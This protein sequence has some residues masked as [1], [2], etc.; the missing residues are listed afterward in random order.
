MK[1][2]FLI[3][4]KD[5][6]LAF[7]DRAALILM[8]AAPFALTL[9]MGFVT[10]RFSG[11]SNT[12]VG[13]IP[14]IVVNQDG[15]SLGNALVEAFQSPD[16]QT[17][18]AP[19]T[20]NDPAA[21]RQAVDD[22]QAAAAVI[23]PAGFTQSILPGGSAEPAAQVVQIELYTNPTRSTSAGVASTIVEE[24]LNRLEVGRVG[25]LVTATQLLRRGIA[26]PQQAAAIGQET[27]TRLAAGQNATAITLKSVTG[28]GETPKF[29]ILAYMA[30][31][32]ALMF[33]MYTASNGGRTLLTERYQGT[34]PRLLV[35][36]TSTAQ[37]FAGKVFGIFLTGAAQML[38][39][40]LASGLLFQLYWGDPLGVLALVLAA[41]V[42]A[43]GWGLLITA[44]ARTP[45]QVAG[46]GSAI[47]LTFGI[48]GGSFFN[49][50]QMPGWFQ[51]ISRVTPNAWGISGFTTLAMGGS[52]GDILGPIGAL[53]VMGA[54]LFCLA[55]LFFNRRGI[56]QQ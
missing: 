22:D 32:M 4:W 53:L 8:L 33:L 9:G 37:V 38:I 35:S 56:A 16:L 24:F 2:I 6:M 12:G 14:V 13:D 52:I 45:G 25:G 21:A 47:M 1:K 27:G 46:V 50:D 48:L 54:V 3:G 10:G 11:S 23:I 49:L 41:V 40:I 42:G 29:D 7:R 36:P 43:V 5:V 44:L 31:G 20:M 28:S 39:L 19:T 15:G 18:V 30:P 55:V 34:L 26:Q 51:V 17:L